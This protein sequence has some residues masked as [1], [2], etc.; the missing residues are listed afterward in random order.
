MSTTTTSNLEQPIVRTLT[1]GSVLAQSYGLYRERFWRLFRIAL[2]PALLAY[3]WRYFFRLMAQQMAV[4]GWIGFKSGKFALLIAMG[5]IDGAFYSTV[6]SFFF[7]AVA[8][9]V[10]R[11]SRE[12]K[13]A[14]SD[15]FTQARIRIGALTVV[16]LLCWTIFWL[17]RAVAGYALLAALHRLQ[18]DPGFYAMVAILSIPSLLLAGLLSRL[19]LTVPVLMDKPA[20]SLKEAL[21]T[22]MKE[23]EGWEL[24]FMMFL[25]KSAVAGFCLYWLGDYGLDS[26]WQHNMLTETTFPWAQQTLY[27]SIAA[28]VESPLFIAFSILYRDSSLTQVEALSAT[29]TE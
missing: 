7:A 23:T 13:P 24:F 19:A 21:R 25:V 12:E 6:S 4:A 14:I 15:A 1:W 22:S 16:A 5:W 11:V 8:T 9:T 20:A 3:L 2:L 17:G 10:L 27:I 28:A 18:L 29:A 26:L